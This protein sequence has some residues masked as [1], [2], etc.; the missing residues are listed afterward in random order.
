MYLSLPLQ[1]VASLMSDRSIALFS[2]E[3]RPFPDFDPR[4]EF[5]RLA[6]LYGLQ[7]EKVPI[8]E[9]HGYYCSD[10]IEIWEVTTSSFHCDP[11]CTL[12]A[13]RIHR[14]AARSSSSSLTMLSWGNVETVHA[15]LQLQ[16]PALVAVAGDAA[17]STLDLCIKQDIHEGIG[18]Y[19]WPSSVVLSRCACY[20][21]GTL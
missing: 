20:M 4:Q 18:N 14:H 16:L 10:E 5:V 6:S 17:S 9:H 13:Q 2:Y 19:L 1:A 11:E 15:R 7:V 12:H 8:E 21:Y 3:H